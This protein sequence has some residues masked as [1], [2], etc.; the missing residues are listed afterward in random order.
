MIDW[1]QVMLFRD[2]PFNISQKIHLYSRPLASSH[3]NRRL[4]LAG[5][6]SDVIASIRQ[7]GLT[8]L[9]KYRQICIPLWKIIAK[10]ASTLKRRITITITI[11]ITVESTRSKIIWATISGFDFLT[12]QIQIWPG[13]TGWESF[14]IPLS[15]KWKNIIAEDEI[16]DKNVKKNNCKLTGIR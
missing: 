4:M 13:T 15:E 5:N 14:I 1:G 10:F 7:T 11:R 2:N 12:L 16:G 9:F 8:E 6:K 3:G